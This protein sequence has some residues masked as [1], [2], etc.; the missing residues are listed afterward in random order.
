MRAS[1]SP[2]IDS[3]SSMLESLNQPKK[4]KELNW[5]AKISLYS[6][7]LW[8]IT[9]T[10]AENFYSIAVFLTDVFHLDPYVLGMSKI[11]MGVGAVGGL[12]FGVSETNSHWA[13]SSHFAHGDEHG[14]SH[15]GLLEYSDLEEGFG[16]I[17]TQ[18]PTKLT[19]G[20]SISASFHYLSESFSEASVP[21]LAYKLAMSMEE[22]EEASPVAISLFAAASLFC[23]QQT[24]L[25]TRSA[26]K[27]ENERKEAEARRGLVSSRN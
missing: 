8:N 27:R 16:E 21:I 9:S 5:H 14:H 2:P 19:W 1:N 6:Q 24:L 17:E 23:H 3:T 26:F 13:M 22:Q 25:N 12:M 20:Q 7:A 4:P 10:T 15:G 18:A 11:G